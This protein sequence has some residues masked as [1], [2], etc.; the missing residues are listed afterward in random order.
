MP[1]VNQN[2]SEKNE[3]GSEFMNGNI[4]KVQEKA[5]ATG[6]KIDDFVEAKAAKHKFT[7]FQVWLGLGIAALAVVGVVK[8][9]G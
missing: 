7:K 2:P 8:L 1:R 3:I 4:K 5:S 9:L 6:H